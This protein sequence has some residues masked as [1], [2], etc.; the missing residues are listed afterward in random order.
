VEQRV[1]VK[2]ERF[3]VPDVCV[4]SRS[5]PIEQIVTHRPILC[6][7]VRSKRDGIA[8]TQECVNDYLD[9]GVPCVWTIDP[10]TRKARIHT[11]GRSYAPKDGVLR[12]PGTEI[13]VPLAELF[14]EL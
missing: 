9:S 5:Q 7:E 10:Q 8:E 4:L 14:A 11:K 2:A 12:V 13:A 3:R 1:Q 6:V